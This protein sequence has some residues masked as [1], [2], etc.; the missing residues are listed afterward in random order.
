MRD[1]GR[2]AA[3]IDV[4]T[5][6]AG[7]SQ[8]ASEALRE[9]GR[10]HR[11]A[12][13]ADRAAIG[14]LVYDALRRR[15]EIAWR[16]GD[17]SPRALALGA[18][19][20]WRSLPQLEAAFADDTHAPEPLSEAE[21]TAIART[22]EPPPEARAN[23]PEWLVP[24]FRRAFGPDWAEEG[25]ALSERPPLDLRVNTLVSTREKAMK[26]LARLGPQETPISPV[27]IRFPAGPG[28]R[29]PNI[30][31]EM[32][33]QKGWVEVQDE[34]SQCAA[35]LTC[36]QPGEQV[37]DYCAGAGGKTL[38]LAAAMENTGQLFAYD[39]DRAR[40]API[41]ER[42]RRART[43]NVQVRE[44]GADLSDL[45]A[46][47]HR[48]L[49]DAPCTGS[50]VWRR[51]PDAKWRLTGQALER[52]MAEQDAVLREAARFVRPGGEL[53]YVTC[54]VLAEE[55]GDCISVFLAAN[56]QFSRLPLGP[57]W[58][59]LFGSAPCPPELEAG[60]MVLS[61]RRTGTDGFF[62]AALRRAP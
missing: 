44:A 32:P 18:A 58:D 22:D 2:I 6:I 46:R 26:A 11:F 33:Y 39:S 23:I 55:N 43:R 52:R 12:G 8:P 62:I 34:G 61:P 4:L 49:V 20:L 40:L 47:M 5:D 17:D 48:V 53:I 25:A 59:A 38:A 35:L 19:S 27:G 29:I 41:H 3:A 15:S 1:G 36:A 10:T 37:L 14:N 7:R 28:G 21:R 42:L 54:S 56:P 51:H 31:I 30:T 9:W 13:A 45:E 16:M 60:A 24:S 57:R 50:G